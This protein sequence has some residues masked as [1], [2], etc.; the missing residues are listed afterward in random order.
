MRAALHRDLPPRRD[1]DND[2]AQ[3]RNTQNIYRVI[4]A[5]A[6]AFDKHLLSM[7][8]WQ[9]QRDCMVVR[10]MVYYKNARNGN[11]T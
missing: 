3:A 4:I 9:N 7:A 2:Y 6:K 5:G 8:K 1:S 11:Y 10:A